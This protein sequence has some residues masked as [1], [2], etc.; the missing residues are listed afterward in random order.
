MNVCPWNFGWKYIISYRDQKVRFCSVFMG[1]L[2]DVLADTRAR[3]F[4]AILFCHQRLEE[5]LG[6]GVT[7]SAE[8]RNIIE[9]NSD[10][11]PLVIEAHNH[12]DDH[13]IFNG[14]NYVTT[15]SAPFFHC[16]DS[17]PYDDRR[18]VE[19]DE[20]SIEIMG[21]GNASSLSI[22]Y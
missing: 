2:K 19:I 18:L 4:K 22:S 20:D 13:N 6:L 11:V 12:Q 17:D 15:Y 1:C 14:V 16:S 5:Q 3:G 8:I 9:S 7:N 10:V 21:H